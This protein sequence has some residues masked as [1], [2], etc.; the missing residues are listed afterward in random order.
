MD[1]THIITPERHSKIYRGEG[2]T[3]AYIG[4]PYT[5]SQGGVGTNITNVGQNI[6]NN[7]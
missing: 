1:P 7:S 2:T 3:P 6:R 4:N 5:S